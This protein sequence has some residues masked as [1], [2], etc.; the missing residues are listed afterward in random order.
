MGDPAGKPTD[1]FKLF[2]AENL[3]RNLGLVKVMGF[4]QLIPLLGKP[5]LRRPDVK[6]QGPENQGAR[7]GHVEIERGVSPKLIEEQVDRGLGSPEYN[8]KSEQVG[9]NGDKK[10]QNHP[11][12]PE[13]DPA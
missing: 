10:A 7:N 2:C 9:S 13:Q 6:T 5:P 3:L 11:G 4:F 1:G 8:E 12:E